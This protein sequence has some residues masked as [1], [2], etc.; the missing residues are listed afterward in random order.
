MTDDYTPTPQT[1]TVQDAPSHMER[2]VAVVVTTHLNE[3]HS[4]AT[5]VYLTRDEAWALVR[6]LS[7]H[8]SEENDS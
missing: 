5:R 4:S 6:T 7:D 3:S 2:P 8:L 1:I